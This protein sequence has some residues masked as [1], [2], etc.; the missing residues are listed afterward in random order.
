MAPVVRPVTRAEILTWRTTVNIPTA[1]RAFGL[2]TNASYNAYHRGDFPVRVL[3]IGRKLVVPTADLLTA[4]GM[5]D[6]DGTNRRGD[7]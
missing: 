3:K 1:G 6:S 7:A 4:L 5:T 2:G